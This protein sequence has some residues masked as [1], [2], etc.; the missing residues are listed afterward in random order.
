MQRVRRTYSK[1]IVRELRETGQSVVVNVSDRRGTWNPARKE[2]SGR[3]FASGRAIYSLD[4][5]GIVHLVFHPVTGGEQHYDG[6]IPE[7]HDSPEGR[8]RQRLV[9]RVWVGYAAWLC[10]GFAVGYLL[11]SGSSAKRFAIGGAGLF[12]AMILASVAATVIRVGMAVR[13]ALRDRRKAK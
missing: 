3:L 10:V 8:R 1:A 2:V 13:M 5:E 7:W 9:R 12:V 11:A 6:P 4:A